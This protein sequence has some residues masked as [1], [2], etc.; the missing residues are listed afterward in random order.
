MRAIF[1]EAVKFAFKDRSWVVK[2]LIGGILGLIPI[3]NLIFLIGYSLAVLK[4]SVENKP[5][6]LPEWS[7]WMDYGKSGL[8]GLLI[9]V[10][11]SLPMILL[12]ALAA[13]PAAGAFFYV[14]FWLANLITVPLF[15]LALI[16]Y[17]KTGVFAGSFAFKQIWQTFAKDAQSYIV[18]T[19]VLAVL[20]VIVSL[21]MSQLGLG[22]YGMKSPMILFPGAF[23]QLLLGCLWFWLGI[24][25]ARIYG[26]IYI[27]A[28]K[29]A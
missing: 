28:H 8:G 19:L 5:A 22:V 20:P 29:A 7:R 11:Y 12:G 18:V 15:T 25:G 6:Q 23:I 9:V 26:Q 2:I 24:A 4:D 1:E 10:V 13:A 17:A 3:V 16:A 21:T 14:L 27:G